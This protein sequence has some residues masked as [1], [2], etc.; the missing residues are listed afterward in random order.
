MKWEMVP[1]V[2]IEPLPFSTSQ[3]KEPQTEKQREHML[4]LSDMGKLYF[5]IFLFP[6]ENKN[7]SR[8]D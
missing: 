3:W 8:F 6:M 7:I 5:G 1:K 4:Y 2:S